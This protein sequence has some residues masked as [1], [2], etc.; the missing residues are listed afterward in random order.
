MVDFINGHLDILD[1]NKF[2]NDV[3]EYRVNNYKNCQDKI[4]E[5]L[6]SNLRSAF[7]NILQLSHNQK[8]DYKFIKLILSDSKEGE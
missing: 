4:K 7:V 1:M 8:P 2:M 6:G 5:L 3:L